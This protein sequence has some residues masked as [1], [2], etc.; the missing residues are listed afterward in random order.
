MDS[1]SEVA[2]E[3]WGSLANQAGK[4]GNEVSQNPVI[5][6]EQAPPRRSPLSSGQLW[7][8]RLGLLVFVLICL[9]LG[10]AL[11]ILP[12]TR[13]W[14]YNNL[15]LDYPTVRMWAANTFVRGAFSGLGLIDIWLGIWEAVSYRENKAN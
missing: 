6:E 12:W 7:A 14:T 11:V 3:S 4:L 13:V 10:I 9:E 5:P 1:N 8:R 2:G 15:L